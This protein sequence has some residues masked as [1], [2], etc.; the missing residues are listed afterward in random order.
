MELAK[1]LAL[2]FV[3]S[4]PLLFAADLTPP[5]HPSPTPLPLYIASSE[6][7]PSYLCRCVEASGE[8]SPGSDMESVMDLRDAPDCEDIG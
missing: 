1:L 6:M 7:V 5:P 2:S 8:R 4:L 3:T